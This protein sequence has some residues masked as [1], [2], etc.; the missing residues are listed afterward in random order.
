MFVLKSETF[1]KSVN[2]L[3]KN[4]R[5]MVLDAM[6]NLEQG[7]TSSLGLHDEPLSGCA[8]DFR[9]LR[10]NADIRI[11]YARFDNDEAVLCFA[12]H[13]QTAYRWAEQNRCR[14][15]PCTHVPQIYE[16]TSLTV[17][18][19]P[20]PSYSPNEGLYPFQY[21]PTEEDLLTIGVPQDQ[22]AFVRGLKD[23]DALMD[24]GERMP[25]D[26]WNKLIEIRDFPGR[27]K[28]MLI[29]A[30]A[31]ASQLPM[32]AS[33]KMQ[34]YVNPEAMCS[35]VSGDEEL[36]RVRDGELDLWRIFLSPEQRSIVERD[37]NGP[38]RITGG[39]GTGK[40]V[41][42]LHRTKWLLEHVFKE[43]DQRILLTTYTNNLALDL[44]KLLAQICD[45]QQMERVDVETI[46]QI[47]RNVLRG[48]GHKANINYDGRGSGLSRDKAFEKARQIVADG[49]SKIKYAS[50]VV[51]ETQDMDSFSLRFI[52]ALTGNTTWQP[53]PNSLFLVGDSRQRIYG[54]GEPLS[55]HGI[56]TRGRSAK[57]TVNYRSTQRICKRAEDILSGLQ[58][59]DLEDVVPR[60][61]EGHSLVLGEYP[62]ER[63]FDSKNEMYA[64]VAKKLKEWK[65]CDDC[66]A[67]K[68]Y[69]RKWSDYAIITTTNGNVESL[70]R[71]IRNEWLPTEI[72]TGRRDNSSHRAMGM[73]DTE[74]T[75]AI[76]VMTLHRAKGLEF[77]GVVIVLNGWDSLP[78]R[79]LA[80]DPAN[81]R[82]MACC[83]LY[84][85]ITRAIAHVLI[86]G[87]GELQGALRGIL[88]TDD[89]QHL[90][91]AKG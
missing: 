10:A 7:K 71:D 82:V 52:A 77:T 45:Q 55:W 51:D 22:I 20:L 37:Y 12:G 88:G 26:V 1:Y 81:A 46:D 42:A 19:P 74:K 29:S 61:R 34:E 15:N 48:A 80:Q 38:A 69:S 60:T 18:T 43:A 36:N 5:Q 86:V 56:A 65:S 49:V 63:R 54:I 39:A 87:V 31:R 50:V 6:W 40:T 73:A 33:F 72:V 35:F 91:A 25:F 4:E 9:S 76:K 8:S 64:Y 44:R 47:M 32:G 11:I 83:Q 75:D 89:R 16:N 67:P 24:A 70:A 68:G 27:L 58:L 14:I 3:Q 30:R 2:E 59:D 53:I 79:Q 21:W 85:A 84:T 90:T 23:E 13:H 78:V 57:L 17:K 62:D 28:Q 66:R 41:V